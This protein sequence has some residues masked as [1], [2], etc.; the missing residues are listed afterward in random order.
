VA[1]PNCHFSG[2]GMISLAG[3][4]TLTCLIGSLFFY[5]VLA[6]AENRVTR[7]WSSAWLGA[8]GLATIAMAL[9]WVWTS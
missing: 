5:C 3:K 9:M 4:L 2:V 8:T 7:D 6:G 1:A